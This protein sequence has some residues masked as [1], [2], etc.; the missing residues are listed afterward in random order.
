MGGAHQAAADSLAVL[1]RLTRL[2]ADLP[3]AAATTAPIY[4]RRAVLKERDWHRR[5]ALGADDEPF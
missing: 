5:A 1:T 3:A 4:A 2:A